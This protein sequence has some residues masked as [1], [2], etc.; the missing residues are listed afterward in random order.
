MPAGLPM[1]EVLPNGFFYK[2]LSSLWRSKG[3]VAD[4]KRHKI[5]LYHG[6]S[7]ELPIGIGET[8]VRSVVTV[9]DLIFERY[10]AQYGAYEVRMHRR[11][12]QY[13]CKVA[14]K[15][16]AI[17]EQTKK[18]LVDLYKVPGN[19]ITVCYQSCDPL[20]AETAS[21]DLKAALRKA[22][23]LPEHFLLYVGSIIERKNLLR[24]CQAMQMLRSQIHLPLVVVGT[25]GSYAAKVQDFVGANKLEVLFMAG[26]KPTDEGLDLKHT[27][28]LAALYQMATALIYPSMFEGFGIPVLEA[29]WSG[30]PVITSNT[31]CLPETAGDAALYVNPEGVEEIG[32]AILE[33]QNNAALRQS[34][35]E[36]GR[37]QAHKFTIENCTAQVMQVYQNILQHGSI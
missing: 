11:K 26:Q 24:I 23:R 19:K 3:V 29:L 14:D 32:A 4:L 8:N 15:V 16:T 36:K 27:K 1:Q 21:D 33:M 17:S 30:T 10:P 34:L 31:S 6:L 5:D 37:L 12:I 20:F 35:V 13:A 7:H 22:Y 18:D 25:G 28:N 9:H 2:K